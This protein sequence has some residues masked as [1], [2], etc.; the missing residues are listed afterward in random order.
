M[1]TGIIQQLELTATKCISLFGILSKATRAAP[2]RPILAC[3][4]RHAAAACAQVLKS[5]LYTGRSHAHMRSERAYSYSA[6]PNDYG[7]VHRTT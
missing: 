7:S 4:K 5:T 6:A 2:N 3:Y 1:S